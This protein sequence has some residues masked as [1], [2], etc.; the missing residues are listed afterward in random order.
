MD[1]LL[2]LLLAEAAAAER[3]IVGTVTRCYVR[4]RAAYE[5]A[6][7]ARIAAME[8]QARTIMTSKSTNDGGAA[9]QRTHSGSRSGERGHQ[10]RGHHGGPREDD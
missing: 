9:T 3:L 7:A 1:D 2:S 10:E 8:A 6:R 4:D 5:A